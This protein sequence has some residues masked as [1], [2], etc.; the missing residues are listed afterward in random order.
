[1]MIVDFAA[2][3]LAPHVP[4]ERE[5]IRRALELPPRPEMGDAAF[6]CFLLSKTMK[7]APAVIAAELA[8]GLNGLPSD[9][10]A[11]ANGP[12]LNLF[13]D[14]HV[15]SPRLL[16]A[17]LAPEFGQSQSGAGK[18]IVID[19]SS[20]NIAKPFGIGH[21][22]STMI[23]NALA[24]LYAASGWDVVKV[25]HLGDWGTQ[26]GKLIEAYKRWGDDKRLHAEPIRES[27]RLY[28]KFHEAAEEEP[29]LEDRAREWFRR[30]ENGDA[31]AERLWRFFVDVSLVEFE[32]VYKRLGVTFDH[33]LGESFYN[34][35]MGAVIEALERNG[36]L[37]E[38]DG[39]KVVRLDERNMPPCLIL[40]SDG[41]T[42]Y[43]TRDLATAIYRKEAMG[44]DRLLYVV[45][46]EQSLHFGQVFAV[47][48]KMGYHW[49]EECRHIAFGLMKIGGQKMSTR[50]GKVVFLDEVLDEAVQKAEEIITEKNPGLPDIRA[51][52]EA[53]GVG[54][55]IFGDLRN[56]RQLEVNFSLEEALRF[57]GETGPYVQYTYARTMSLLDKGIAIGS[58]PE[59]EADLKVLGGKEAW[60]CLKL[61]AGFPD[62]VAESVRQNEPSE[63]ARFLL[64]AAKGFNRY[65]HHERI[66]T[67]DP[68]ETKA[69][70]LLTAAVSAVLGKGLGML[71]LKAP[72]RI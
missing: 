38:S 30:L 50:R 64:D 45:G 71:G 27:L 10:R 8:S 11:E 49:T 29:E 72:V 34:D 13:F 55:V 25:N 15:W 33:V 12:Y 9:I 44:A 53:I 52:A 35:K 42:I 3:Y 23:G 19:L 31:E 57:E 43:P 16:E 37:E 62:A 36:L 56:N 26:F 1:M 2:D 32:R 67:R 58:V 68:A 51:V 60:I 4:V 17:A 48:A 59:E 39:A 7:K 22:R 54:A 6:P 14:P 65:Y 24:N 41:T 69:K 20:P 40:K 63:L 28:V 47:L 18:R 5:A 21:L 66:I 61:L 46:A 70:L